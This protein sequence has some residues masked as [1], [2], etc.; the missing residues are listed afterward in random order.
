EWENDES[1]ARKCD[2]MQLRF[3]GRPPYFI[4]ENE[5]ERMLMNMLGQTKFTLSFS[6]LVSPS[7]Q[8]HPNREYLTARWT[9]AL[10][11]G[12]TVAGIP[13]KSDSVKALL[14]EGA[15]LDLGTVDRVEG[16]AIVASAVRNWTPHRAK[17][18]HLRSL[19]LLDWRWRY[20]RLASAL[21]THSDK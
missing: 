12:A 8:T 5:N 13:P 2:T 15:L 11:A 20:E 1:T 10:S 7:T 16:I 18:N 6:N 4:D 17:Q 21:G 9:D 14:W 19:E 3:K